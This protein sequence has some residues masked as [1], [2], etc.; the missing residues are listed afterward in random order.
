MEVRSLK[1]KYASAA[2]NPLMNLGVFQFGFQSELGFRSYF[3]PDHFPYSRVVGRLANQNIIMLCQK[4]DKEPASIHLNQYAAG[5]M[6]KQYH[7]CAPCAAQCEF[8]SLLLQPNTVPEASGLV[9][10]SGYVVSIAQG[11]LTLLVERSSYYSSGT[12]LTILE[13]CVPVKQR[14]LGTQ[15]S[16]RCLPRTLATLVV[17]AEFEP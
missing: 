6:R 11:E 9:I 12:K 10:I 16:L 13:R 7:L 3:L 14:T 4:C 8:Y 2:V 5:V 15:L 1:S 17:R